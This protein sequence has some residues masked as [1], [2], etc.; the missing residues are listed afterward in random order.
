[1]VSEEPAGDVTEAELAAAPE[2]V[3]VTCG[4]DAMAE[5]T[6]DDVKGDC[7]TKDD[8]TDVAKDEGVT[9]VTVVPETAVG[10]TDDGDDVTETNLQDDALTT[11]LLSV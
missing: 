8:V 2:I 3:D 9:E 4:D 7:V 1:M 11:I 10:V 6:G 5:V